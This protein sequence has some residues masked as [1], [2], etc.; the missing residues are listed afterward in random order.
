MPY[1]SPVGSFSANGYALYDMSGNVYEWCWDQGE[2]YPSGLRIDP[3]GEVETGSARMIRGGSWD[4]GAS[5]C[6][7]A[8]RLSNVTDN[9]NGNN[10]GFR[11]ARSSVPEAG[12][13][14]RSNLMS[15]GQRWPE[16]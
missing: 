7:V 5:R 12:D 1:T 4:H 13:V 8:A 10:M 9:D 11:I 14:E 6:C 16:L 2:D 15:V 3:R